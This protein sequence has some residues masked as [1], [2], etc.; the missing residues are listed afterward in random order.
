M[1]VVSS[2]FLLGTVSEDF[3]GKLGGFSVFLQAFLKDGSFISDQV[4][5]HVTM[6]IV[7]AQL[8]CLVQRVPSVSIG[9]I[10]SATQMIYIS[11]LNLTIPQ[12]LACVSVQFIHTDSCPGCTELPAEACQILLL[13]LIHTAMV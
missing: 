5:D 1:H 10:L 12:D 7:Y 13:S 8:N 3:L 11:S 2:S 6:A 4:A 9:L